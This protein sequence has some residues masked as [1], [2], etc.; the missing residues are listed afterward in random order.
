[1]SSMKANGVG[2][3][4]SDHRAVQGVAGPQVTGLGGLEAAEGLRGRP[5]GPG[6]EPEP[7]KVPLQ[8]ARPRPCTLC[9]ADHL[10]HLGG[11]APWCLALQ[12]DRQLA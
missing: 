9:R 1:M 5:V 12:G 11:G 3:A 7:G 8:R 6:V 10:G 2:L 4:A